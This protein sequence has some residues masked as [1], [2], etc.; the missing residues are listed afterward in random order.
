V[1]D[2]ARRSFQQPIEHVVMPKTPV[3]RSR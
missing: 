1:I 2:R 3:G